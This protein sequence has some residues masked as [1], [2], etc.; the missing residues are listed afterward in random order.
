V[1]A[2]ILCAGNGFKVV[3]TLYFKN[4]SVFGDFSSEVRNVSVVEEGIEAKIAEC[5]QL[6]NEAFRT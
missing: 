6:N 5:T 4:T 2:E 3:K 1:S